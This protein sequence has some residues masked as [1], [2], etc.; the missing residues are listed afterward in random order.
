MAISS[1]NP[2]NPF[3]DPNDPYGWQPG[4]ATPDAP[5]SINETGNALWIYGEQ[6]PEA[7]WTAAL[8]AK[9]LNGVDAKSLWAR[10]QFGRMYEGYNAAKQK[11]VNYQWQNHLRA[12]VDNLDRMWLEQSPTTRGD[13]DPAFAPKSRWQMRP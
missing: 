5:G 13:N 11:N 9:G 7:P 3:Y 4:M 2:N 8:A 12:N 6:N 10:S 1:Y